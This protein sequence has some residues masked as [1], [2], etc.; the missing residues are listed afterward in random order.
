MTAQPAQLPPAPRPPTPH[1]P[2]N[3]AQYVTPPTQYIAPPRMPTNDPVPYVAP[4]QAPPDNPTRYIA[5]PQ[6]RPRVT[7][8]PVAGFIH[9][10]GRIARNIGDR[11]SRAISIIMAVAVG[12]AIAIAIIAASEGVDTQINR[13]LD[14]SGTQGATGGQGFFSS[15]DIQEIRR[16]LHETRDLLTILAIGFTAAIVGLVTW[17]NMGQLR[18]Q[19]GIERQRG[20]H[21]HEVVIELVGESLT[22][23]LIGG[24]LGIVVGLALCQVIA[25]ILPALSVRPGFASVVAVFPITTL[26]TFAVTAGIAALFT[27]EME[28]EPAL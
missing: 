13:I 21:R 16:I 7:R 3:P 2:D 15:K 4:P 17:V 8:S 26:L 9:T 5:S 1:P 11:R 10:C 12:L 25:K 27:R 22:L 19:I 20:V 14:N 18:R 6:M 28:L 24:A 23:C